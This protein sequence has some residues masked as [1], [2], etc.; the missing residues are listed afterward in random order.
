MRAPPGWLL[1]ER[2]AFEFR[3]RN[4]ISLQISGQCVIRS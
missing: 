2:G 1:V 3:K 4:S